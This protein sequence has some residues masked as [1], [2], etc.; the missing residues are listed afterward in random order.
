MAQSERA[1]EPGVK[2][3]VIARLAAGGFL[4]P[5]EEA[6]ELLAAAGGDACRL[7]AL[8]ARRLTGEPL[9]WITGSTMFC[10]VRVLVDSGVYVPRP[11]SQRLALR[12]AALLPP[13]GVAVDVCTGSGAIAVVLRA[14]R[15]G[16]R[17]VATDV[18]QRAVDCARRN[19]VEALHSDL[20][21]ALPPAL[22][23]TVD[24][25]TAVV[26]YVP[27]SELRF[28]QRDTFRF[29]S[30]LAYDGGRDGMRVLRRVVSGSAPYVRAGGRLLLELGGDEAEAI[31]PALIAAGYTSIRTLTDEDGDLRGLEALRV[32]P[33]G[34]RVPG[35]RHQ[36]R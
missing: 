8:V 20:V 21:R 7:G 34:T 4:A 27:T 19:G 16:A 5:K 36:P 32:R 24:V 18:D 6:D 17:V 3:G 9:A 33:T 12:A 28:L 10:G 11:H 35:L 23:G 15:P 25:F 1:D 13:K 2:E 29:E 30:K 22:E 14:H 26:P 31:T